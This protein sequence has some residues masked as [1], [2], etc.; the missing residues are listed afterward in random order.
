MLLIVELQV[1]EQVGALKS[2]V[3]GS[4]HYYRVTQHSH[5]H[6]TAF[7]VGLSGVHFANDSLQTHLH[8][9]ASNYGNDVPTQIDAGVSQEHEHVSGCHIG[10]AGGQL[11][12]F[13]LHLH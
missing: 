7:Q 11:A 2:G 10:V 5:I 8:E 12:K 13:K 1:H 9:E 4:V 3:L 6:L